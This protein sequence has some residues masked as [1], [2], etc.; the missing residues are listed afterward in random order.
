MA[1]AL[2]DQLIIEIC[3]VQAP[4]AIVDQSIVEICVGESVLPPPVPGQGVAINGGA[5]S[6]LPKSRGGCSPHIT[7]YDWCLEEEQRK[8][9]RIY[10]PPRCPFGNEF[11]NA[12]PWDDTYGAIPEQAVTFIQQKAIL[13]PATAAGNVDILSFRVPKGYDGLLTGLYTAYSGSGFAQGSGDIVWRIKRNQYYL[14]DL[15]NLQFAIGSTI[16]PVP[17]T[18]GQLLFSD[19]TVSAQVNVPNLSGMIQV[20]NSFVSVG[21]FGFFWPR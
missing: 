10:F 12:L 1:N 16:F 11:R 18:E 6:K 17:L 14:K 8:T 9:R 21:C 7:H 2:V 3:A 4:F 15:S 13:T 19:Q 20:G 5:S